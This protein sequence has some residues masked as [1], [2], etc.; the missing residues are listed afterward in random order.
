MDDSRKTVGER[1]SGTSLG[2]TDNVATREGHGPTL[3]LDSSGLCETLSLDFVH[4][5]G[6][7]TS[8]V[9]GCDGLRDV[10]ALDGHLVLLA[11]FGNLSG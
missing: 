8:L 9:E 1:L 2:N 3:S 4:D 5:V 7:E 6:W 10:L 11:V